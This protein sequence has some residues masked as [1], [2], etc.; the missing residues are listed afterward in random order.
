LPTFRE[1]GV[2]VLVELRLFFERVH[3]LVDVVQQFG[4]DLDSPTFAVR[5]LGNPEGK[6]ITHDRVVELDELANSRHRGHGDD[7]DKVSP[8]RL[9]R[10]PNADFDIDHRLEN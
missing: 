7:F 6:V 1:I 8:P 3:T 4:A 2:K 5:H 9:G 10:D